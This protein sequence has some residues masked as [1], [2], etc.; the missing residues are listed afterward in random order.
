MARPDP[1]AGPDRAQLTL[2]PPQVFDLLPALYE[3]LARLDQ[4]APAAEP[5]ADQDE[6]DIGAHY[7]NLQPLEPKDLPA[8]ILPLKAQIRRGL[9]ELEKLPD[10]E[11]T[12][13]EQEEEIA[14]LEERIKRQQE[15]LKRMASLGKG[16]EER[17]GLG[18]G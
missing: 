4:S 1:S 17:L 11:R 5:A 8:A 6:R 16:V 13:Q 18:G 9:K 10:M 3:I 12:V 14:E 15:M 2:P 7:T